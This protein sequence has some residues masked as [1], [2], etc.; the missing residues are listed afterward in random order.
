M[1]TLAIFL[2]LL[3]LYL[4][5]KLL[6]RTRAAL[7][8]AWGLCTW[9]VILTHY[10]AILVPVVENLVFVVIILVD[11]GRRRWRL[12]IQ[13]GLAQ[14]V[15]ALLYLPWIVFHY[16]RSMYWPSKEPFDMLL[17]LIHQ[18]HILKVWGDTGMY[19]LVMRL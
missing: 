8:V 12:V 3:S 18:F 9:A 6:R 17:F 14:V 10:I 2:G 5:V 7:W 1:Y 11:R 16:Q 15:L 13:W 4:F 19:R